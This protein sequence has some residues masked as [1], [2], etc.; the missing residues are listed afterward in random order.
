[1]LDGEKGG[2]VGAASSL[3]LGHCFELKMPMIKLHVVTGGRCSGG[4]DRVSALA[5]LSTIR[6]APEA[7]L[8][9]C[10]TLC[11]TPWNDSAYVVTHY[12]S[13]VICS[14]FQ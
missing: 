2:G 7:W 11:F 13:P 8:K 5:L 6:T 10:I 1:V 3:I 12:S 4:G 9:G 14:R